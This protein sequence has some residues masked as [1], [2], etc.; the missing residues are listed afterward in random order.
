MKLF[1]LNANWC[2]TSVHLPLSHKIK[3]GLTLPWVGTPRNL[4][5]VR[6]TT[7]RQQSALRISSLCQTHSACVRPWQRC[8]ALLGREGSIRPLCLQGP[9]RRESMTVGPIGKDFGPFP[10]PKG[11]GQVT[12]WAFGVTPAELLETVT[13][14]LGEPLGRLNL[15]YSDTTF[16]FFFTSHRPVFSLL[17]RR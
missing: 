16:C 11:D 15:S 2:T 13:V 4:P 9:Q 10:N 12:L 6:V 1:S 7:S 3:V 5:M 17:I 14:S 8:G